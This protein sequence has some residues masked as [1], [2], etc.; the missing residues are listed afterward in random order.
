MITLE[1]LNQLKHTAN[2]VND[3]DGEGALVDMIEQLLPVLP[4]MVGAV[5]SEFLRTYDE[6]PTPTITMEDI[7]DERPDY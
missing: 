6:S 2:R 4:P 1:Y 7:H 5:V 3:G